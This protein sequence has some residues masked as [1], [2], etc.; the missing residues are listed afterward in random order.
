MLVG[1]FQEVGMDVKDVFQWAPQ[2]V[3]KFVSVFVDSLTR[4]GLY[5][6]PVE[7]SSPGPGT[8]DGG[9]QLRRRLNPELITFVIGCI[10]IGSILN[11]LMRSTRY[12]PDSPINLA[13]EKPGIIGLVGVV[14][15]V[16]LFWFAFSFLTFAFCKILGGRGTWLA[17]VSLS[18]Q[19]FA[20]NNVVANF[21]ALLWVMIGPSF[22]GDGATLGPSLTNFWL[23]ITGF[24]DRMYFVFQFVLLSVYLTRAIGTVHGFGMVRKVIIGILTAAMTATIA[25]LFFARIAPIHMG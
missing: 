2:Y 23:W 9:T 25:Y 7:A 8:A 22:G 6:P 15:I 21:L 10:V 19:Y 24:P 20:L 13:V 14:T 3:S 4:P 16:S 18:L 5:F 12:S 17:T 11:E 1:T